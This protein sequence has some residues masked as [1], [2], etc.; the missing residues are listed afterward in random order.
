MRR[1]RRKNKA[2]GDRERRE[3]GRKRRRREGE[4][5]YLKN[6]VQERRGVKCGGL[7]C[8]EEV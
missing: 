8:R 5:K 7:E 4:R 1:N 2:E 6:T 3:K